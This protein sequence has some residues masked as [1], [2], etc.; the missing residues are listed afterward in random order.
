MGR[1]LIRIV[2]NEVIDNDLGY[3]FRARIFL[4]LSVRELYSKEP[5]TGE[6]GLLGG[7]AQGGENEEGFSEC[8]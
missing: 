1:G 3:L 4:R 5:R 8:Y 6:W 2:L 7:P